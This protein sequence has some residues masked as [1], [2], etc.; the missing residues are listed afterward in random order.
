MKYWLTLAVEVMKMRDDKSV[1]SRK[2]VVDRPWFWPVVYAV[3]ALIMIGFI[4]FYN[5]LV[6]PNE[7]A[8]DVLEPVT[9]EDVQ[10]K[11]S[12]I[13][14]NETLKYPFDEK[15]VET[16]QVL[17]DFYDVEADAT[18]REK[19]LLVFN[20]TF[21][22]STGISIGVNGEPFQVLAAMSGEVTNIQVDAFTG[23]MVE[24]THANGLVTRYQSVADFKVEKGDVVMQGDPLATTIAN[25]W[26]PS[27]GVH[28]HF[29]VLKDGKPVNPRS[30]LSF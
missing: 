29:E 6:K 23:N 28:L 25:E 21:S 11:P 9:Y 27:A 10:P 30:Y 13:S 5:F 3:I 22:T 4:L 24:V 26:N 16:A 19:A 8:G 1:Q 14:A 18:Q 17:Q 20:Q 2:T 7:E 12:E 15:Y